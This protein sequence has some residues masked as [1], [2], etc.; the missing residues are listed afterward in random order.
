MTLFKIKK[1]YVFLILIAILFGKYFKK[2]R[3]KKDY[4]ILRCWFEQ[5]WFF[6]KVENV[7]IGICA[8]T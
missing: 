4:K 3:K 2:K 8:I 1:I 7:T 5:I 6:D